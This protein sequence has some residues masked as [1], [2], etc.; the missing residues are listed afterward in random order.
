MFLR[1]VGLWL[2]V[3]AVALMVACGGDES[4]VNPQ[5]PVLHI[6]G[7]DAVY[8]PIRLEVYGGKPPFYFQT[9]SS[10]IYMPEKSDSRIVHGFLYPSPEDGMGI[11]T[12]WDDIRVSAAYGATVTFKYTAARLTPL[13][14]RITMDTASNCTTQGGGYPQICAGSQGIAELQ[15]SGSGV[16]NQQVQFSVVSGDFEI[17]EDVGT[18]LASFVTAIT[19]SLGKARVAIQPKP[20]APTQTARI[21]A[22]I[23]T[24]GFFDVTETSLIIVG[25]DFK[26][27]PISA[28]WTTRSLACPER[29]ASFS[30]YGGTPPYSVESSLGSLNIPSVS[31]NGGA[32][33]LTVAKCGDVVLT[34]RDATDD[35]ATAAI[36]YKFSGE[37]ETAPEVVV[38]PVGDW[39]SS[40]GRVSCVAGSVFGFAIAGGTPPYSAYVF[41]MG[42]VSVTGTE[43]Q[44]KFFVPPTQDSNLAIYV[45]DSVGK[46]SAT[47]LQ[48]YC[49]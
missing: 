34:A 2:A 38:L 24:G 30:F 44:V 48:I 22:K 17:R 32:V 23:T 4:V 41:P 20:N 29:T 12:A 25:N 19:D 1:R 6:S 9:N 43:G 42:S 39:G 47:T 16:N 49:R 11:I 3:F 5:P 8:G 46:L 10:V 14:L 15:L 31:E 27:L 36:S 13:S 28:T 40:A 7:P 37:E 45:A 35:I 18:P 33:T 26:V 21:R